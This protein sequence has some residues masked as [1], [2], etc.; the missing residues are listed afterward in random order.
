[1]FER[2]NFENPYKISFAILSLGLF[3]LLPILSFDAGLTD[4]EQLHMN[5]G[6]RILA[7]YEGTDSSAAQSPFDEKGN[8][9]ASVE[10]PYGKTYINI[11]GGFFDFL[12]S[13]L[14]KYAAPDTIDEY[15][16][17][18]ML[19]AAFGA[20]LIIFTGL[21]AFYISNKWEVALVCLILGALTPRIVGHSL[22][23]PK[24]IPIA[25]FFSFSLLQIVLY[26]KELPVIKIKRLVLLSVSISLAI[27]VR[28][29]SMI[30]VG[31]LFLFTGLM[32]AHLHISGEVPGKTLI[33]IVALTG[34]CG[35][36]GYLGCAFFW[37]WAMENPL[38][39]P[40]KSI[41]VFRN[42][43]GF[44]SYELFE[45]RWLNNFEIPWYFVPKTFYITFPVALT[46]GFV[47]F[48][49]F[50][51][52]IFD[53]DVVKNILLSLIIFSILF[54]LAI[55]IYSKSNIYDDARH[56]LFVVPGFIIL[57]G[58]AWSY[59]FKNLKIRA[60]KFTTGAL[61]I[62]ILYEPLSFMVRNH[63]LQVMYFSPLI[64]GAKGAFKNF[65]MDYWGFSIRSAVQWI[66]TSDST[67]NGTNRARIRF[68]YG[69]QLKL[70]YL[71][72][73]SKKLQYVSVAENSTDWDYFIQLP[74]ESKY[75]PD[76]LYHWPPKGTVYEVKVDSAPLC[77]VIKNWRISV[78]PENNNT[79][80][81]NIAST[82]AE[83]IA[84]GLSYYKAKNFNV[85]ILEFKK[86]LLLEPKNVLVINN[87][88]AS[89][90]ELQMFDDAM[91]YADKGLK[92]DPEYQLLRNNRAASVNG[93]QALKYDE[94]YFVGLSYNYFVQR[95]FEK[96]IASAKRILKYNPTSSAA[97]NNICSAY[98]ELG[99]FQKALDACDKGLQIVP[100]EQILKNN[101]QAAERGLKLP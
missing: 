56:L 82:A 48:W 96:C 99:Q 90:N 10:G 5:H 51:P 75:N 13:F 31:Y 43:T 18:H 17:K 80:I 62:W 74:V 60:L 29:G 86:G 12:S 77:A 97:Y 78:P 93:K 91:E 15:T 41:A 52:K 36:A 19:G 44:N 94:R 83:F 92:I 72:D 37:P 25:S 11:Y 14:Y 66:E 53:A 54:P 30:L 46:I 2:L 64:G 55:I 38:L 39:N 33:K 88:A 59:I 63:P 65:E 58:F 71:T 42:F 84:N 101:K 49:V 61:F 27:A 57:A 69:E 21:L 50:L 9:K 76:L 4:D 89:L 32:V 47:L 24:D 3:F 7:F 67:H 8:W 34:I 87:I 100:N 70:K 28:S 85:A 98:N 22:N 73:K 79:P 20:L 95:E 45:G 35:I 26:L 40:Y 1:M 23:N 81:V 6:K 68:W 16:F